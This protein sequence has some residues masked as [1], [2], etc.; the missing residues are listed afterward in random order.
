MAKPFVVVTY[1][2]IRPVRDLDVN[3]QDS[4]QFLLQAKMVVD[5]DGKYVY[6]STRFFNSDPLINV[7]IVENV[8]ETRSTVYRVIAQDEIDV[9]QMIAVEH[10]KQPG[11]GYNATRD[12]FIK[13][14]KKP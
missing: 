13:E 3:Q 10:A 11:R 8:F 6:E 4:S 5:A 14:K 9:Y 1:A 7:D 12:L 2:L